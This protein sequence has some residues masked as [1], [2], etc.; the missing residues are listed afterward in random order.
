MSSLKSLFQSIDDSLKKI[1]EGNRAAVEV[2]EKYTN[3]AA[4]RRE[5]D[6]E[7]KDK[8]DKILSALQ[9][10]CGTIRA[11]NRHLHTEISFPIQATSSVVV[12][13]SAP[14][15]VEQHALFSF[16][17]NNA[18]QERTE[19]TWMQK[20]FTFE[21]I[22]ETILIPWNTSENP[23]RRGQKHMSQERKMITLMNKATI[24]NPLG[25]EFSALW[26]KE[27]RYLKAFFKMIV[28]RVLRHPKTARLYGEILHSAFR[29]VL[30]DRSKDEVCSQW[31]YDFF[32][33]LANALALRCMDTEV[34]K[35]TIEASSKGGRRGRKPKKLG[36]DWTFEFTKGNRERMCGFVMMLA[37]LQKHGVLCVSIGHSEYVDELL[38]AI[39]ANLKNPHFRADCYSTTFIMRWLLKLKIK[40]QKKLYE[41]E[42]GY[43]D[44]QDN[45]VARQRPKWTKDDSDVVQHCN[46]LKLLINKANW[47]NKLLD[48]LD[49]CFDSEQFCEFDVESDDE[50]SEDKFVKAVVTHVISA[51]LADDGRNVGFIASYTVDVAE[52]III[53]VDEFFDVNALLEYV[54]GFLVEQVVSKIQRLVESQSDGLRLKASVL[55][56]TMMRFINTVLNHHSLKNPK[57]LLNDFLNDPSCYEYLPLLRKYCYFDRKIQTVYFFKWIQEMK[58]RYGVK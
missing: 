34:D 14:S 13:V 12:N 2:Y 29:F 54:L 43:T 15:L 25:K 44:D 41:Q 8:L 22:T 20:T 18:V 46:H 4:K 55:I 39:R 37:E 30:E 33:V 5:E 36:Q 19:T 58:S 40:L 3:D 57:Q 21:S 50:E 56:T 7:K 16:A 47:N 11:A 6:K 42:N 35:P 26:Y 53:F 45:Y 27:S 24:D 38:K 52:S 31:M 48:E 28:A 49:N 32:D 10:G 23:W 17:S 51:A 1:E 9:N